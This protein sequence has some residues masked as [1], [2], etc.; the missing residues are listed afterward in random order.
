M[1]EDL[2]LSGLLPE[3]MPAHIAVIMDGNGRWAKRRF[4]PRNAGHRQGAEAFR[5]TLKACMSLGIKHLSVYVFSTENWRRPDQEVGFL[6]DLLG[7]LIDREIVQLKKNGV[8]MKALGRIHALPEMLQEKVKKLE[9]ETAENSRIQ[10]NLLINYG[11]RAEIVDAIKE[12][13]QNVLQGKIQ[14][15]DINETTVSNHLYTREIPDP[16]LLIRTGG[17]FRV[18]NFLLWQAAYTELVITDTLWPDFDKKALIEAIRIYQS[19]DRRFGAV[20]EK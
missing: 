4:L 6:M 2:D 10:A 20:H 8:R 19:R 9:A 17:D 7:Y 11:G 5:E 13:S 14:S 12:I 18:S 15:S 1:S 16:D 3:K